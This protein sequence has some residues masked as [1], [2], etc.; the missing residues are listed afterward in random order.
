MA[1]KMGKKQAL[2]GADDFMHTLT[3]AAVAYVMLFLL[4]ALAS[5]AHAMAS[6]M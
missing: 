4:L 2:A 3:G 5:F 6:A 1:K